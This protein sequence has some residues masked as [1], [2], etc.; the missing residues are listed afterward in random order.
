MTAPRGI[1]VELSVSIKVSVEAVVLWGEPVWSNG[2]H[3]VVLG[4]RACASIVFVALIEIAS[5]DVANL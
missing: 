2:R 5:I 4:G 1:D 3:V